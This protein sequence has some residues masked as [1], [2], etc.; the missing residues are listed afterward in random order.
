MSARTEGAAKPAAPRGSS[1]GVAPRR[2][3]GLPRLILCVLALAGLPAPVAAQIGPAGPSTPVT[4]DVRIQ[5]FLAVEIAIRREGQADYR[6][7][8]W[9]R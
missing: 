4:P 5:R 2:R 7:D 8:V 3:P 9:R 6:V 1:G